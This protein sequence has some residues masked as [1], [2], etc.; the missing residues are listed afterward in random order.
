MASTRPRPA[1]NVAM[2]WRAN[3]EHVGV[4]RQDGRVHGEM[5]SWYARID[6]TKMVLIMDS[7]FALTQPP[8]PRVRRDKQVL[9]R[10]SWL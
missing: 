8:I 7:C 5:T 1:P 9:P 3:S 6:A 2:A 4:K 10:P